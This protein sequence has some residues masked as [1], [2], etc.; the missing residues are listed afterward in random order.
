MIV[1]SW[2][3]GIINLVYCI[4]EKDD[5]GNINILDWDFIN[6]LKDTIAMLPCCGRNRYGECC[7]NR[8][9]YYSIYDGNKMGFCRNHKKLCDNK[10]N[11]KIIL[12]KFIET[13]NNNKCDWVGKNNKKCSKKGNYTFKNHN[14]CNQHKKSVLNLLK[15]KKVKNVVNKE[16]PT[17]K[18]RLIL[19]EKLESLN[20]TII[21]FNIK[22]I[23]IENQPVKKNAQMK[24]IASAISDYYTLK[25]IYEKSS[26]LDLENVKFINASNKLKINNDNTI[27]VLSGKKKDKYKLTKKLAETYTK[28]MI[29]ETQSEWYDY[30]LSFKKKDD[31]CDCYLQGIY[32]LNKNC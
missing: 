11:P 10:Y 18:L 30:L 22:H 15:P 14:Y 31:L 24:A 32:Y 19:F 17:D 26:N 23:I 8:I 21:E 4:L 3:V 16:Y 2:D 7:E 28:Q 5:D 25:G 27:E 20:K 12:K 13:K 9:S 6:L 29:K 1:L